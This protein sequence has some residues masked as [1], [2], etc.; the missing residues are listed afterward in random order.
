[1]HLI[2]YLIVKLLFLIF[3]S[4]SI[5]AGKKIANIVYWFIAHVI[6]YRKKVIL[7]NLSLVYGEHLPIEKEELLN[8]IYRNFVYLWMEFL[9]VSKLTK[10][11]INDI[12]TI[13]N[14]EIFEDAVNRNNGCILLSGHFGNFEWLGQMYALMGYKLTG[15]AKR[16]GN[17][18][19]NELVEK[20]RKQ[21]NIGVIYTKNAIPEGLKVLKNNEFLAIVTDQDARKKGIFVDFMGLPSSTAVGPAIFHLRTGAPLLFVIS[22]RKDYGKFDV[23]YHLVAPSSKP[24]TIT[25]EK[26]KELTQLHTSFLDKWVR[27][28]PDQWFWMHRRWKT[29]PVQTLKDKQLA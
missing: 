4:L 24:Q 9:Q 19:V 28:Y 11:S 26:I 25:D 29:K 13:H 3:S 6:K 16:Q 10:K 2:E 8:S 15:I 17:P 21:F 7:S 5:N 14:P 20:N 18:Y 12:F 1:M 22:I 23:Y 27:Q